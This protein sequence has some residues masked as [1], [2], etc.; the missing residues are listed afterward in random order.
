MSVADLTNTT[1]LINSSPTPPQ[2]QIWESINFTSNGNSYTAITLYDEMDMGSIVYRGTGEHPH[3]AYSGTFWDDDG[4]RTIAIS[5]GTAATNANLIAWLESNATQVTADITITYNS[6]EVTTMGD[7]GTIVLDTAGTFMTDDITIEYNRPSTPPP[8][9]QAKTNISPTTS[10]QTIT[11]DNGYDG[12]SSVQIN[13]MPSGTAG[14]PV[15]T[16]GTVSSN[17]ISVTPSVTN[18]AG[19]ISSGTKTGTAVTVSASELVSGTKSITS[20]GTTDVT[21]YANASV[22]AGSATTPATTVTANPSISVSNSGL[23]TATA[24]A[25]KSVTPTV[26]AGYVSSGTA[27]TITVSGSNTSQL[28]V[29]AGANH[30]SGYSITVSLINPSSP[31]A[32]ESCEIYQINSNHLDEYNFYDD[33]T[34]IGEVSSPTGST[35]I[36]MSESAIGLVIGCNGSGMSVAVGSGDVTTTGDVTYKLW[37]QVSSPPWPFVGMTDV[38][39]EASGS[40]TITLSDI[41]WDDD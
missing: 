19:Y 30:S 25:T 31:E 5:G 9:L 26:S 4:D 18:V 27:G 39:F 22:A 36:L 17:S 13:A 23:I 40:G 35:A 32:F 12:L 11:A 41:E 29:Y 21:N 3:V 38:Y 10:S 8:N 15:A 28:T 6:S 16:K 20:S 33:L 34:K 37:P 2:N 1:W 7:S 14:T 24:S